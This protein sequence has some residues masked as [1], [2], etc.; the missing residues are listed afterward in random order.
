MSD[1][2]VERLRRLRVTALRVRALTIAL[3]QRPSTRDPLL[4]Q[5][6]CAA[7]RVARIAS[8]RLRAHPY[9]RFQRDAGAVTILWNSLI[10]AATAL[11]VRTRQHALASTVGQCRRLAREVE[12]ARALTWA[13]DLSDALGRSQKELRALVYKLEQRLDHEHAGATAVAG[14]ASAGG[15]VPAPAVAGSVAGIGEVVA[16]ALVDGVV[17]AN[18]VAGG[19]AATH[20]VALAYARDCATN[21]FGADWPYLAL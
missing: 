12:G 1:A 10:A 4:R 11:C 5:G 16:N 7:W 14:S 15:E 21:A 13:A 8:G 17:A 3:A 2:E 20:A 18:A 9:A 19:V 6:Q